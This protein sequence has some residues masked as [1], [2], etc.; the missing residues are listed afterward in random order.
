MK[1]LADL[2]WFIFDCQHHKAEL[3]ISAF[4]NE[5]LHEIVTEWITHKLCK[6]RNRVVK[7]D[8]EK[9]ISQLDLRLEEAAASLIFGEGECVRNDVLEVY[10]RQSF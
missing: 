7:D 6:F 3:V 9:L 10:G 1:V 8:L 5:L 4:L 2:Q